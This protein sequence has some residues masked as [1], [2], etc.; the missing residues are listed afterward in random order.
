MDEFDLVRRALNEGPEDSDARERARARLRAAIRDEG[1]A[2][3]RRRRPRILVAS[4]AA[5]LAVLTV[6]G[7]S[8]ALIDQP[9]AAAEEFH[10]LAEVAAHKPPVEA[11]SGQFVL[12]RSEELRPESKSFLGEGSS[13]TTIDRLSIQTW[14]A[15]DGSSYRRT[16]VEGV[17]FASEQDRAAWEADG[18]PPLEVPGDVRTDQYSPT[19]APWFDATSLSS[20]PDQ[21]EV[22][23]QADPTL[24]SDG[25]IYDQ[26]GTFL[27][28]GD[29]SPEVRAALFEVASRLEGIQLLGTKDDPQG[30]AGTAMAIDANGE[31]VE[32]I[33]DPNSSQLLAIDTYDLLANGAVGP[34]TSWR[35]FEST[36]VVDTGPTKPVRS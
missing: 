21:L 17:R 29:S 25:Q 6:L 32:L 8:I 5:C 35:S 28:Q 1:T 14:V 4:L 24:T 30:R 19:D 18:R 12:M 33:F 15:S 13:F 23:L 10:H 27:A 34:L 26:I 20:N 36:K 11:G 22:A 16:T 3:L 7:F 9:P 31:R 2:K